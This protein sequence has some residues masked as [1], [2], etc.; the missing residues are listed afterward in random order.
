[1]YDKTI[2]ETLVKINATYNSNHGKDYVSKR[3]TLV[4]VI[5]RLTL[6]D[7]SLG[8]LEVQISS[9]FFYD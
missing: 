4:F 7:E 6:T 9:V 5:R 2:C 8:V 1:M 3:E